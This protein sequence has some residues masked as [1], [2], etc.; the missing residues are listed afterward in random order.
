MFF[1]SRLGESMINIIPLICGLFG[2]IMGIIASYR[3]NRFAFEI[4]FPA[5]FLV[6]FFSIQI[7]TGGKA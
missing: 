1:G 5:L 4:I 7:L 3:Q 6:V 2:I